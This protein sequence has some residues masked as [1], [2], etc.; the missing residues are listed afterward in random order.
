MK[1]FLYIVAALVAVSLIGPGVAEAHKIKYHDHP[2]LRK[3]KAEKAAHKAEK[4]MSVK[5]KHFGQG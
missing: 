2:A 4:K 1:R 5:H 3:H